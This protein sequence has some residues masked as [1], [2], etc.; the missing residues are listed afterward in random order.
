[1][2]RSRCPDVPSFGKDHRDLPF[3]LP[4]LPCVGHA[5]VFVTYRGQLLSNTRRRAQ[6]VSR[7][8]VLRSF[9]HSDRYSS[10]VTVYGLLEGPGLVITPQPGSVT[11]Q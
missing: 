8:R 6:K 5:F 9:M 1:M 7:E 4:K 10:V 2:I 11:E 3:Y